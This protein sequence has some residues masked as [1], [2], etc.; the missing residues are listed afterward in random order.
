LY[1]Y[2]GSPVL[3]NTL[4]AGNFGGATG[5]TRDDVRGALNPGGDYNLIGDGT[6]MSGLSN[7]VNGNLV[8]SADAPIDPLLGPLQNN[9]GPTLTHALQAG[10]PAL[11]AGDPAQLG[12]A[13]QRGVVRSGGVNIGAYQASAST[14]ALTAPATATAGVPFDG[15]V[16]A[17]DRLGQT[18]VGYTGTVHFHSSD[19]QAVLPED[20]AFSSADAGVHPFA[21]GVTLGTA[22]TQTVTATDTGTASLTGSATVAVTPAAADHLLF[23]QQPTDTAAG[24]P[25]SPAVTVEVVDPYGNVVSSDNAD[26][27]TLALGVNPSGGTLSGTLTVTVSGGIATF[28]D[29]S[30]DLAGDGYTLHATS[31]GLADADS[32]AFRITAG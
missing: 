29:L 22:G 3:H 4:I 2:S 11:N 10:S 6:G 28:S 27:V 18:A 13:D 32:A 30:I 12:V 15:T 24:Q 14:F 17:L 5:T 1:V 16:K 7:G 21:A 8:G 23:L 19:G 26:T 25:I 9:G 31:T 20:Y